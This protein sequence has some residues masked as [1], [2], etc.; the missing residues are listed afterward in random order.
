MLRAPLYALKNMESAIEFEK[1]I[2]S[3][4]NKIKKCAANYSTHAV[5]IEIKPRITGKLAHLRF[6]YSTSDAA[7]QNTVTHCTWHACLWIEKQFQQET[8]IEICD[9][10]IDG[11]GSSD[12]KVSFYSLLNGR[13]VYV[14]SE[15]FLSHEIIAKTLRTNAVDM[16]K[17]YRY[18]MDF[19]QWHAKY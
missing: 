8:N 17:L 19:W 13:G 12:K 14:I 10:Y 5:L 9:Y 2:N 18:S 7:G 4:F 1:W 3:N 6:I 15:C 11:V 16:F